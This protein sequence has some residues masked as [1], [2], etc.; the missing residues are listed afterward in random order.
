LN[1]Q[2]TDPALQHLT[3]LKTVGKEAVLRP[4]G[5]FADVSRFASM[6]IVAVLLGFCSLRLNTQG[7]RRQLS[8]VAIVLSLAGAFASGS[9]ASLLVCLPLAAFGALTWRRSGKRRRVPA[10]LVVGVVV[11]LVFGRGVVATTS[12]TTADFY[13]ATL[14][15]SSQSFEAGPRLIWYGLDAR[16]GIALGG[17]T[18]RGTGDQSTGRR[19]LQANDGDAIGTESGWGSVAIEWGLF[20]F[21]AWTFWAIGWTRLAV[22]LA[23]KQSSGPAKPI[24]PL[25]AFYIASVLIALFSLGSGFFENYISNIF[26]WL[27]SGVAFIQVRAG[28]ESQAHHANL[29]SEERL[30]G[31]R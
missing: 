21:C 3:V 31:S 30:V 19:Y 24:R 22:R 2:A 14:N 8:L 29:R 1:P 5:P 27:L 12:V 11:A 23:R 9:R 17:L 4:S 10:I 25:I 6:T 16:R 15:P 7:V 26:F 20:G 13:T 28:G 18:G